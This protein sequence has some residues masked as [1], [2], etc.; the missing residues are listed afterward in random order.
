MPDEELQLKEEGVITNSGS[1]KQPSGVP[2]ST[3]P[4]ASSP[5]GSSDSSLQRPD[6]LHIDDDED[7]IPD[8]LLLKYT[9]VDKYYF[10]ALGQSLNFPYIG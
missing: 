2:N 6:S 10:I 5:G 1:I 8:E 4:R 3:L 7:R 9:K